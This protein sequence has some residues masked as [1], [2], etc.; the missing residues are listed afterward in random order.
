MPSKK[1]EQSQG[2]KQK[3]PTMLSAL[4][5]RRE[6]DEDFLPEIR[7]QWGSMA[8]KERLQFVL[9]ALLGLVLFAGAII[10]AYFAII[11]IAGIGG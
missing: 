11:A 8:G 1:P 4:F 7:A 3:L 9:G 6:K 5:S 2:D 10:L